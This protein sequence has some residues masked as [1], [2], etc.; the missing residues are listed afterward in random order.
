MN[1]TNQGD[2]SVAVNHHSQSHCQMRN[3]KTMVFL[4]LI[5]ENDAKESIK[6]ALATLNSSYLSLGINC[7]LFQ[8]RDTIPLIVNCT[9]DA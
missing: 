3:H 7:S 8:S 2:Q 1:R 4:E 5:H 9:A 6:Y